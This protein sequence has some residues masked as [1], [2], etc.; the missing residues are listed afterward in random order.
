MSKVFF[1]MIFR[2]INALHPVIKSFVLHLLMIAKSI[3]KQLMAN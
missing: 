1:R 2:S 3:I